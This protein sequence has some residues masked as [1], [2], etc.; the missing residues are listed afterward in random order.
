MDVLKLAGR[1]EN[2]LKKEIKIVQ[3]IRRETNMNLGSE[4]CAR[5]YLNKQVPKQNKYRK[6]I[7]ERH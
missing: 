5:I 7:L 1:N 6:H 2:D 4:K 3:T